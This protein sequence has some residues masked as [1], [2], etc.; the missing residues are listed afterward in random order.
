MVSYFLWLSLN[1]TFPNVRQKSQWS[2]LIFQAS[3]PCCRSLSTGH[4][5]HLGGERWVCTTVCSLWPHTLWNSGHRHWLGQQGPAKGP[6]LDREG[7]AAP[8]SWLPSLE[9]TGVN[10][11][12]VFSGKHTTWRWPFYLY[13][14]DK[15]M[16]V[17]YCSLSHP[18]HCRNGECWDLGSS[19]ALLVWSTS[20]QR[21]QLLPALV[22]TLSSA[23]MASSCLLGFSNYGSWHLSGG[24]S[25][26]VTKGLCLPGDRCLLWFGWGGQMFTQVSQQFGT[27]VHPLT[28]S[29]T[30]VYPL[31]LP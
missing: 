20:W 15:E 24:N 22:T 7:S 21:A 19:G 25:V 26:G 17:G 2:L 4:G 10:L 1:Y 23:A 27:L 16:K 11:H 29:K 12:E 13:E 8:G 3:V 18:P 30:N 28:C 6:C 14:A 5:G 9:V 31:L